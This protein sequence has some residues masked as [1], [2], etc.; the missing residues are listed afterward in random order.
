MIVDVKYL[1]TCDLWQWVTAFFDPSVHQFILDL[2]PNRLSSLSSQGQQ[3]NLRQEFKLELSPYQWMKSK[4][5][6]QLYWLCFF[7]ISSLYFSSST[8]DM[9][10]VPISSSS[11]LMYSVFTIVGVGYEVQGPLTNMTQVFTLQTYILTCCP[12]ESS[13][14]ICAFSEIYYRMG[15]LKS[16]RILYKKIWY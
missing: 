5:G 8:R 11:I 1:A 9:I 13:N 14:V 3:V 16:L 6:S 2:L 12:H 7:L 4:L 10:Q 15:V